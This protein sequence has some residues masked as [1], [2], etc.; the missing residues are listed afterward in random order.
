M[1]STDITTTTLS[2]F[3][4][5]WVALEAFPGEQELTNLAQSLWAE[6]HGSATQQQVS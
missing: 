5:D 1:K 2:T 6:G 3:D 4:Q